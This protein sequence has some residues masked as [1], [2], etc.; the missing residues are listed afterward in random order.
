MHAKSR[1]SYGDGT[2]SLKMSCFIPRRTLRSKRGDVR[3]FYFK[4][5]LG[6]FPFMHKQQILDSLP[7]LVFALVVLRF[8]RHG[9]HERWTV[10]EGPKSCRSSCRC[11]IHGLAVHPRDGYRIAGKIACMPYLACV[12]VLKGHMS[13]I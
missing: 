8:H 3:F 9:R 12:L 13:N 2:L 6:G 5:K 11:V 4:K 1:R 7:E 10:F